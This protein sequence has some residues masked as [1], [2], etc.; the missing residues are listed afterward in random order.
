MMTTIRRQA[1]SCLYGLAPLLSRHPVRESSTAWRLMEASDSDEE[2]DL[3]FVGQVRADIEALL[4]QAA[5]LD[6]PTRRLRRSSTGSRGTRASA[7]TTRR[8]S[9]APSGTRWRIWRGTPPRR[10]CGS[11]LV[12]GDV[13][14]DER[15]N[16]RR[17]FA[18]PKEDADAIDVLLSSEVGCE[19]LDF[20]FCDFLINYDLPWNPMRIEQRIGRIDRYG[21]KSETVA[22]VNFVTPGTV[23]ADI[24]D[25]CLGGSASSTT[26]S[27][28]ARRS[29]ARSRRNCTTSPRASTSAA[30]ERGRGSSSWRITAFAGSEKSR[31]WS[32]SRPNSSA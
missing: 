5:H 30:E 6:R 17:R 14:D 11:G 25:R 21:Q 24:Y 12:H 13:P 29:S 7:R 20:Q 1:A 28:A 15:A 3:R 19:G 26:R 8:S 27:A 23:D 32:P 31:N 18:L 22:I 9:S 4:E 16:L 10:V 2:A